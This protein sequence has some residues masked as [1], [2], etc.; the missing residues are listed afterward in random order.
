[1]IIL[2]R[3][4]KFEQMGLGLFVHFGLYS[5]HK[6]GEWAKQ[7]LGMDEQVY[8]SAKE[9]FSPEKIGRKESQV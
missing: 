8:Y 9:H 3:I 4:K 6:K 2:Q 5:V 1:M 7:C